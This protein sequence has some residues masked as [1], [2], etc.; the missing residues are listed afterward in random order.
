LRAQ[1]TLRHHVGVLHAL[2]LVAAATTLAA[3]PS[4]PLGPQAG[5]SASSLAAAPGPASALTSEG[6]ELIA[7]TDGVR[8][9]RREKRAGLEFAAEGLIPAAP[10]R[11][12][13]VLTDYPSHGRWQKHLRENRVLASTADSVDVY[14]RMDLP[15]LDDRDYTLHVTWG[16]DGSV[17][18]T[19]FVTANDRGPGPVRGVVRV[20]QHE[21]AFRLEPAENGRS[22]L[23]V[24][25]FHI[26]LGGSLPMWMAKGQASKDIPA[27][28]AGITRQLPRYP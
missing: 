2:L 17:L 7:V 10:A 19:R 3:A 24:Y 14:Q 13:R 21:G 26:D 18:W 9:Y 12:R 27:Y 11:V 4:N 1:V 16:D 28:F 22:T 23:A 20:S 5:T 6:F 8:V 15:L 25:R